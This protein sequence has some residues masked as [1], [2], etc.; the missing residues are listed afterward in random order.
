MDLCVIC[1]TGAVARSVDTRGWAGSNGGC[2]RGESAAAMG[3]IHL[4]T[5]PSTKRWREVVDL[6]DDRAGFEEV[7]AAS[8][9]AA[10]KDLAEAARSPTL[11]AAVRLLAM[12]PQAA[13]SDAFGNSLRR[14]GIAAPDAPMFGDLTVG[15]ATT[16]ERE[17]RAGART[18]FNEIVRRALVGTLSAQISDALPGLFEADAR[19]VQRAAAALGR[20]DVFS[21]TARAFFGRLLADT[22][23]YW[24]DRTLSAE[25]GPG[26]RI[27]SLG[28]RQ[29]FDQALDQYCSEA[30]RIIREFSAAWYGKTLFREGTISGD[31]AAAFSAVALRKITAELQRKRVDRA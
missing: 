22:L 10:E 5:L 26:A 12:V 16:L 14:L 7:V 27:G 1:V 31:R 6:L 9:I 21:R 11:A 17:Q 18:D 28:E 29:A 13:R 23:G 4:A 20:P 19:D 30:T 2:G 8:A 25:I 3:H 15:V 24:L